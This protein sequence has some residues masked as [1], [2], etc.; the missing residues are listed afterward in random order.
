MTHIETLLSMWGKWSRAGRLKGLGYDPV[1]PMFR[2]ARPSRGYESA[3]PIGI[4][5]GDM[6]DVDKAVNALPGVLRLMVIETYLIG[7]S[8]RDVAS[9][10]GISKDSVKRYLADAHANVENLLNRQSLAFDI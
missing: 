9:R 10:T 3:P 8:L 2:D 6:P 7:G 1:C 5:N 4:G